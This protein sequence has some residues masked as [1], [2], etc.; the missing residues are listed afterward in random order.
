M[1]L[2]PYIDV[3]PTEVRYPNS[4]GVASD[5]LV[6]VPEFCISATPITI[7]QYNDFSYIPRDGNPDEF[8]NYL[9][10]QDALDFCNRYSIYTGETWTLPSESQ[11]RAQPTAPLPRVWTLDYWQYSYYLSDKIPKDGSPMPPDGRHTG[12]NIAPLHG[13]ARTTIACRN[14][15]D[16][17]LSRMVDRTFSDPSLSFRSVYF[18]IVSLQASPESYAKVWSFLNGD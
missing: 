18:S 7:R 3:P 4:F 14:P 15:T 10:F 11:I 12:P 2:I 17:T 6:Q 16:P 8:C 9:T 5:T 1:N 13:G